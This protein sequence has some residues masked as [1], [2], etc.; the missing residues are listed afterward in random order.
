MQY[1]W[2]KMPLWST[3]KNETILISEVRNVIFRILKL[4]QYLI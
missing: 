1:L 3:E 4:N 2:S